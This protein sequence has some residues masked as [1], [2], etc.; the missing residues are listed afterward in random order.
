MRYPIIKRI[1]IKGNVFFLNED[2]KNILGLE[3]GGI[4]YSENERIYEE[5]L[6]QAYINKGFLGAKVKV[7]IYVN[8]KGEAYIK[9]LVKE[10]NLYFLGG[11][12]FKG[13]KSFSEE[14]LL[15][16]SD[17]II[18]KVF[19]FE[20]I[21]KGEE[22]LE[23]FYRNRGFYES[24]VFFKE[25][26]KKSVKGRF[27]Q[28]LF[29]KEE[30]FLKKL[31]IG[32]SNLINHP[33]ATIKALFGNAKL[34]IPVYEIYEGER[35]KIIFKGN[36]FFSDSELLSLLDKENVGLDI[37]TLEN[38]KEKILK[39]YREKG[40]FDVKVDYEFKKNRVTFSIKEGKRYI[41]EVEINRERKTIPYDKE[42]INKLIENRLKTLR[43]K[44]YLGVFYEIDERIDKK[45]KRVSV[46][47]RINRGFRYI[48]TGIKIRDEEFKNIEERLNKS[49]PSIFKGE[50]IE[51]VHR[52][53]L[54]KLREKGYFDAKISIE[55][56]E[57]ISGNDLL[58]HYDI[59]V[60]RGKRYTYGYT[61]VYGL[62]KTAFR[63]V[64]YMLIK[65]KYF[66]KKYEEESTWNLMESGIFRSV[67]LDNYIDRKRKKVH[68]FLYLNEAKRGLFEFSLG[69]STF[70][71]IKVS[72]GL[73]LRNL[74]GI[75]LIGG[76]NVSKSSKIKEY[77]LFFR[78]NFLFSRRFL[79][80]TALFKDYSKHNTYEFFSE[81]YSL[82][83]GFRFNPF[84]ILSLSFTN[85][86]GT[87]RGAEKVKGNFSKV[88][89]SFIKRGLLS[90]SFSRAY[91][92]RDYYKINLFFR[93]KKV[94][95]EEKL[96]IRMKTSY[97][98]VSKDAPIFDRFFL[99]GYFNMRGY[100][101]ESIGSPYGER[102]MLYINPEIYLLIRKS[103][104]LIFFSEFGKV[105]NRFPSLY[106]NMKKDIGFSVGLRTPVGLVR[107]DVAYPLDE[108]KITLSKFKFYLSVDFYF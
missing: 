81:G 5:I 45:R 19:N 99:G 101:Y 21:E 12:E 78:D 38:L 8:E 32:L 13:A 17:L 30:N 20:D 96:G 42:A 57:S 37:F 46:K 88:S 107:G 63:E 93:I 43:K 73:T 100:S 48:L 65:D 52:E 87:T 29:P 39:L 104:E 2:I 97:G 61:L 94:L 36:R 103:I 9:V 75:G 62:E 27:T 77:N 59:R 14:E 108:N 84:S 102:Q 33:L 83:L 6:K 50:I 47:V 15:E 71:N 3:E 49:L 23:S 74:F 76:I 25:L 79:G 54:E 98:Y 26:R 55:K 40:F 4:L 16:A 64:N 56:K 58:I 22:K 105:S 28:A 24:F 66:S 35:Y 82:T 70:E 44:G 90:L 89:L 51:K 69:Y 10:N 86:N 60:N 7:K 11:A 95:S 106:K 67:R 68:R 31:S 41:S 85:F 91:G 53:I 80:D 92:R 1:D 34:G 72:G 18:G